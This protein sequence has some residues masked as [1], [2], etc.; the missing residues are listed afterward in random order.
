MILH[1]ALRIDPDEADDAY[2]ALAPGHRAIGMVASVRRA[3]S[4][5]SRARESR[6]SRRG[7]RGGV[8]GRAPTAAPG[9][10]GRAPE[11]RADVVARSRGVTAAPPMPSASSSARPRPRT[12]G[13]R[14]SR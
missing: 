1:D 8:R 14:R 11:R 7:G 3:S 6:R 12:G 10:R 2:V 13:P 4:F 5:S 9:S